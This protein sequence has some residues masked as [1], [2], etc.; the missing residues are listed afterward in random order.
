MTL[1]SLVFPGWRGHFQPVLLLSYGLTLLAGY[2]GIL[3]ESAPLRKYATWLVGALLPLGVALVLAWVLQ[4]AWMVRLRWPWSEPVATLLTGLALLLLGYNAGRQFGAP[5]PD[6]L[7]HRGSEVLGGQ[8]GKLLVR[9]RRREYGDG[10]TLGGVPVG[11]GDE[12]KHFKLI[13]STGTG[14][15]TAIAELMAGAL[16]RGDRAIFADP[17]GAYRK[18]F[19]TASRGDAFLNPFE[20]GSLRWDLFAEIE[21]DYD[22]EQLARSLIAE[23]DGPDRS[24]LNYARTFFTAVTHQL[25]ASGIHDT[26]ELYR[27]LTSGPID[28]LRILVAGTPAQPFLEAGNERMFGSVRSVTATHVAPLRYIARQQGPGFSVRQWVRGGRGVLFL[29]Y[30]AEHLAALRSLVSTWMRLAIFQTMSLSDGDLRLWFVVDELDAL[31]AIDGLKDALARLRKYGGRCVLGFQS[32]AQVSATYGKGEAQTIVE[33]C[34]N[35]LILRCSASEHGGT[36]HF[37]SKLI[38]Q[39]EVV[40]TQ[41]AEAQRSSWGRDATSSTHTRTEHRTTEDA[42]LSSEIEQLPDLEGYLKLASTPQ[43]L[44]LRLQSRAARADD[45]PTAAARATMR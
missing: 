31:G 42:V 7:L 12:T 40:R 4:W 39:R 41:R 9:R 32:I 36:A 38:G 24:W 2:A 16:A 44:R 33:N 21:V 34:G 30:Q 17:D 25:W 19:S 5:E 18:R 14:K 45:R 27:L 3:R 22:V 11:E 37:A 43:W 6:G 13:G 28:E 26:G 23:S 29:P 8:A 35:T 15:S 1:P 20:S 10:L